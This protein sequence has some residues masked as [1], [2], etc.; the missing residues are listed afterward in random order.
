MASRATIFPMRGANTS[1]G[2]PGAA[3]MTTA[4]PA[5]SP[6]PPT[7]ASP[8]SFPFPTGRAFTR[9]WSG[10]ADQMTRRRSRRARC[11]S[12]SMAATAHTSWPE[13]AENL[14]A[15]DKFVAV[16]T[17]SVDRCFQPLHTRLEISECLL[18]RPH[19]AIE[20]G[21]RE[22]D[23]GLRLVEAATHFFPDFFVLA[24]DLFLELCNRLSN[25]PDL[26]LQTLRTHV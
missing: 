7:A 17:R 9:S 18:Q 19:A 26:L 15:E 6:S 8:S 4:A 10:C 2:S 14:H 20:L 16:W 12:V 22:L 23:H 1:R 3:F 13:C 11:R 21:V 24:I 25:E 5:T